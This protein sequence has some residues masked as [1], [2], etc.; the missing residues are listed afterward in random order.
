MLQGLGGVYARASQE[1]LAMLDLR[2][3]F[4][5]DDVQRAFRAKSLKAHPD[6]GGDNDFMRAL[7]IARDACLADA[8]D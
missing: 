6:Q 4:T 5:H 7:M 8:E 3:P 1:A 2:R